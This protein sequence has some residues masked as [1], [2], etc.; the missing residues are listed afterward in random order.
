MV[1]QTGYCWLH[2][3]TTHLTSKQ[4]LI[5]MNE[6]GKKLH[7]FYI[8]KTCIFVL[9]FNRL[10]AWMFACDFLMQKDYS[11]YFFLFFGNLLPLG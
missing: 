11:T 8:Y 1:A 6:A 3:E 9:V 2:H 7:F 10:L 4:H 5:K